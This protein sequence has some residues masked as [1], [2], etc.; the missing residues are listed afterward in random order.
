MSPSKLT[1]IA[2]I[3]LGL[4][5]AVTAR[6]FF[7]GGR[8]HTE[9]ARVDCEKIESTAFELQGRRIEVSRGKTCELLR[10]LAAMTPTADGFETDPADPWHYYG[11]MRVRPENDAWFLIFV[12]RRSTGFRP[13][14]SLQ[15]WRGSGWAVAGQFDAEPVL[16]LL[17]VEDSLDRS[18]LASPA[19]LAPTDQRQPM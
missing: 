1:V 5:L 7:A 17:G 13:E 2:I 10:S 14:L 19:S 8:D 15:H 11:R 16:K 3:L 9:L 6:V 18:L 12:A 4:A